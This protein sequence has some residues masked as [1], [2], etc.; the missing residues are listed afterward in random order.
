M[1]DT[2]LKQF[3][4]MHNALKLIAKGYKTPDQLRRSSEKEY[5]LDYEEA[6]G[7]SYENIQETAKQAIKG[8]RHIKPKTSC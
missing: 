4:R 7:Y 1:T 8:V 3:N 6:L 5:G 2:Q